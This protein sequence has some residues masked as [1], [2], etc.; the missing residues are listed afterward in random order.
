MEDIETLKLK[1]DVNKV[2]QISK[3]NKPLPYTP[4]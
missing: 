1:K 4:T 2:V 3:I